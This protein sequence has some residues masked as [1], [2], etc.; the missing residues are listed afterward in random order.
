MNDECWMRCQQVWGL[1]SPKP[2]TQDVTPSPLS[3]SRYVTGQRCSELFVER[4]LILELRRI[5]LNSV[6]GVLITHISKF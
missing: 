1:A 2:H 4:I 5:R 3:A 6:S